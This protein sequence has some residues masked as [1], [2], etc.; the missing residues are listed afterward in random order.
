[1]ELTITELPLCDARVWL[2]QMPSVGIHDSNPFDV[3]FLMRLDR[4]L[5]GADFRSVSIDRL[6]SVLESGI[7]VVPSTAPIYVD[8]FDKAWEY[9]GWPKVTLALHR[10]SLEHTHREVSADIPAAELAELTQRFPTR[11][12]SK[13]GRTLW[14]SRLPENDTNVSSTYECLYGRWIEHDAKDALMAVLLFARPEDEP[15]VIE[16]LQALKPTAPDEA[17]T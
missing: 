2:I 17:H 5:L 16:T 7:D 1:M 6:A 3:Q 14:L 11:L 10:E 15:R 9:G 13:D 8:C 4:Q 12:T